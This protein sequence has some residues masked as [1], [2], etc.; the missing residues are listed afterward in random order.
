M[1]YQW[2]RG[3]ND[4]WTE[5][6]GATSRYY[7]QTD[8]D[9][10]YYVKVVA[11]GVGEYTDSAEAATTKATM[12]RIGAASIQGDLYVGKTVTVE[13]TADGAAENAT[14]SWY[15]GD[16]ENWTKI[17]DATDATYTLTDDDLGYYVKARAVGKTGFTSSSEA[18]TDAAVAQ[19]EANALLDVAL[20]QIWDDDLAFDL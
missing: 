18:T 11:T 9:F 16:G 20:T 1:T 12:R 13:L 5:I 4:Q 8:D 2:Y 7:K 14:Y 6:E 17:V 3:D 15:R 19:A 10:G